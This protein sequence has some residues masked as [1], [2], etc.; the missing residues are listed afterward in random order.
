MH[1]IATAAPELSPSPSSICSRLGFHVLEDR[2]V[3][4]TTMGI[5]HWAKRFSIHEL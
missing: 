4:E 1:P 2:V 3:G 5:K